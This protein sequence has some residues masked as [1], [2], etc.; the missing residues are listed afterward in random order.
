MNYKLLE[1]SKK[2]KCKTKYFFIYNYLFTESY[3]FLFYACFFLIFT[4]I[5]YI[6]YKSKN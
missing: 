2:I 3:I 6:F 5:Y 4:Y 1:S